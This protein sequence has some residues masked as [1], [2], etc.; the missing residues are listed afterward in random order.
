MQLAFDYIERNDHHTA[1]KNFAG[2]NL[3]WRER[4]IKMQENLTETIVRE[5]FGSLVY[6]SHDKHQNEWLISGKDYIDNSSE[7]AIITTFDMTVCSK[8][9]A[10][11]AED[12]IGF[13][14]LINEA[15]IKH[16]FNQ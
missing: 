3:P 1:M 11:V 14:S 9:G 7:H 16:Y 10:F 2:Y 5:N 12:M 8:L 6:F 15:L 4:D 13:W